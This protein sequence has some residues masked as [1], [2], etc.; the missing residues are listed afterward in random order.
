MSARTTT[1]VIKLDA[2]KL[3]AAFARFKDALQSLGVAVRPRKRARCAGPVSLSI[4][5]AAY[6]RRRQAR[7]RRT[8]R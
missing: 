4:D 8:R 3:Q 2:T 5:G 6:A 7:R 1:V